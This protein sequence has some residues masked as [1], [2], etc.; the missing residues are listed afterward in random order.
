MN[1]NRLEALLDGAFAIIMTILA[2]EFRLPEFKEGISLSQELTKLAPEFLAY[3]VSFIVLDMFW[4]SHN[5]LFHI[6]TKNVNRIMIQ[7][8]MAYLALMAFVPFST[9]MLGSYAHTKLAVV[10]Y[11]LHIFLLGVVNYIMLRYALVSDEIDTEHVSARRIRQSTIRVALTPIMTALGMAM[12]FI[13]IP[14]ALFLY[15]FPIVFNIIPGILD[16]VEKRFGLD[17]GEPE[18]SR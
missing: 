13:S 3:L 16:W 5:K 7:I 14:A 12:V 17:F 15:A 10:L 11:G 1:K 18:P 9:H 2:V 6:F 4:V 8:N